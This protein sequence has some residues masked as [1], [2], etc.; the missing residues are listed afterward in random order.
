M[1]HH[2][3]R[4]AVQDTHWGIFWGVIDEEMVEHLAFQVTG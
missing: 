2:V 3:I 4:V 1:E